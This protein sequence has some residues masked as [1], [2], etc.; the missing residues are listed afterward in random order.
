M[1][2]PKRSLDIEAALRWALRDELPKVSALNRDEV[3]AP[4]SGS[5]SRD[6]GDFVGQAGEVGRQD[7]GRDHGFGGHPVIVGVPPP[8]SQRR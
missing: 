3:D 7:A 8:G 5:R 6:P 4:R 2:D 1:T